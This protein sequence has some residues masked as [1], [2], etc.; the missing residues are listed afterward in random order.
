MHE[1]A[2]PAGQ[3]ATPSVVRELLHTQSVGEALLLISVLAVAFV[4]FGSAL[5]SSRL[6]PTAAVLHS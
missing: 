1:D 3:Q 2:A 6:G 4:V 5:L